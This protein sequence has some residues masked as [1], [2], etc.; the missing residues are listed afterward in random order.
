M[1]SLT[2]FTF[3][4]ALALAPAGLASAQPAPDRLAAARPVVAKLFPEGTYKRLMGSA[5]D[6]LIADTMD[7]A[8]ELPA[9]QMAEL[10][11]LDAEAAARIDKATV[12]EIMA[13]TDPHYRERTQASMKAMMGAMTSVMIEMEPD[14][15][16][17]LTRAYARKF[18]AA[19]LGE[20]DRFFSTPTGAFYAAESMSLQMDPEMVAEMQALTPKILEQMPKVLEASKAA[21]AHLPP[22][23]KF[24]DLTPAE[25]AKL[26]EMLGIEQND[27][28]NAPPATDEVKAL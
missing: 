9:G 28:E 5:F 18:T 11:G 20:L 12:A 1:K 10:G 21:T 6:K 19:Q 16:T 23:R 2:A 14:V 27:L 26:S 3:A 15:R 4:A 24:E 7:A 22:P 25:R 8:M 13:I 17:A